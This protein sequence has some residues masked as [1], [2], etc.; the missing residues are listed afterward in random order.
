M[1]WLANGLNILLCPLLMPVGRWM[2]GFKR[3]K[4][5]AMAE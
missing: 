4:W 1:L 5:K 3:K 2:M